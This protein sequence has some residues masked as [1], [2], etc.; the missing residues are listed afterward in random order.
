MHMLLVVLHPCTAHSAPSHK[1][2][3]C[4]PL[5]PYMIPLLTSIWQCPGVLQAIS[6]LLQIRGGICQYSVPESVITTVTVTAKQEIDIM[7]ISLQI[8]NN[9]KK[10]IKQHVHPIG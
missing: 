4:L 5:T 3:Y 2:C 7:I 8:I 1:H 6:M 10:I 9:N